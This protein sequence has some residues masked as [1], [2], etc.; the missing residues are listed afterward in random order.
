[1]KI[2]IIMI[3]KIN[4][5]RDHYNNHLTKERETLNNNRRNGTKKMK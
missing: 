1:M 2:T 5:K 4:N 3:Y